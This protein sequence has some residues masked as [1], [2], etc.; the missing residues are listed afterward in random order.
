[1]WFDLFKIYFLR[2]KGY[3]F[4]GRGWV[5]ILYIF[6]FRRMFRKRCVFFLEDRGVLEYSIIVMSIRLVWVMC[7]IYNK[8]FFE[9]KMMGNVIIFFR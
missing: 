6:F 4:V 5:S 1:M 2:G 8:D 9:Y 7:I 3:I